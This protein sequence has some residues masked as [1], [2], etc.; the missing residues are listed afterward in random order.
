MAYNTLIIIIKFMYLYSSILNIY[1]QRWLTSANAGRTIVVVVLTYQTFPL[2]TYSYAVAW[3]SVLSGAHG[4][5][6]A[7]V[8][9]VRHAWFA[10]RI[11]VG[12]L[13]RV[14]AVGPNLRVCKTEKNM[15][16]KNEKNK[17]KKKQPKTLFARTLIYWLST[18]SRIYINNRYS[19]RYDIIY[20]T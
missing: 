5:A 17:T 11:P 20:N 10:N 13:A 19:N 6:T 4:T 18:M 16:N 3:V 9:G 15:V 14:G 2:V 7:S 12:A 1:L 8:S